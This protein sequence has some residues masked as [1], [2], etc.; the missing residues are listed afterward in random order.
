MGFPEPLLF[1]GGNASVVRIG[2]SGN[3]EDSTAIEAAWPGWFQIDSDNKISP[4]SK[5]QTEK[6][7]T[8]VFFP[9]W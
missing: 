6:T 8:I 7:L 4:N 2:N 5:L 1:F 3:V 9:D